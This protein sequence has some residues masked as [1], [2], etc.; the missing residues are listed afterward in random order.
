MDNYIAC[1][2]VCAILEIIIRHLWHYINITNEGIELYFNF[3]FCND[4]QIFLMYKVGRRMV[5]LVIVCTA[6]KSIVTKKNLIQT[7]IKNK[8]LVIYYKTQ[9]S[10]KCCY[11]CIEIKILIRAIKC[12]GHR[13]YSI[14]CFI[15]HVSKFSVY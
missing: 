6:H 12:R 10:P 14:V 1:N 8:V 9:A 15:M 5:E 11:V 7:N 4:I 3:C 2:S 13:K